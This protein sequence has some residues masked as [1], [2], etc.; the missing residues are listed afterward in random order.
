M[1]TVKSRPLELPLAVPVAVAGEVLLSVD[2]LR[3]FK[4]WECVDFSS[5]SKLRHWQLAMM[6]KTAS[7][8]LNKADIQVCART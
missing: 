6:F 2:S 3:F 5:C 4:L 8:N 7:G 1:G